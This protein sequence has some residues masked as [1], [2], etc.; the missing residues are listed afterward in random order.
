MAI[1]VRQAQSTDAPF[2]AWVMRESERA[3]REFGMWDYQ[4]G[5][6]ALKILELW[7]EEPFLIFHYS[8]FLIAEVDGESAAA[9]CGYI[10]R[11]IHFHE[12]D[13]I[14]R[15]ILRKAGWT[16]EKVDKYS[17]AQL[18]GAIHEMPKN[19]YVLEWA[20][21]KPGFR[22]QGIMHRLLEKHMEIARDRGCKYVTLSVLT[23]N[24]RA[25]HLYEQMGFKIVAEKRTPEFE[26]A[27]GSA[28]LYRMEKEL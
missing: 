14:E 3:H 26:A 12:W 10:P 21:T 6:D 1:T 16:A 22:N 4:Y 13:A 17:W 24:T 28:G 8:K 7:T 23:D 2:L 9:I 19:H 18:E 20:A 5:D 15:A 27:L 25:Q 11:E